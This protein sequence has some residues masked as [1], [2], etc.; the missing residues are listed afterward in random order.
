VGLLHRPVSFHERL[1]QDHRIRQRSR[2]EVGWDDAVGD[3][4]LIGGGADVLGRL[5]RRRAHQRRRTEEAGEQHRRLDV[6]AL[7]FG[8]LETPEADPFQQKLGERWRRSQRHRLEDFAVV[9]NLDLEKHLA[10]RD[11][12]GRLHGERAAPVTRWHERRRDRL[13]GSEG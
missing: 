10:A 13:Q 1:Y 9:A 7:V 2:G 11:D 8:G 12:L 4:D 3:R 5:S 6:L